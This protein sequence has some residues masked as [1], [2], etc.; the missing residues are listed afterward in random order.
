MF[1]FHDNTQEEWITSARF[2]LGE[3][4]SLHARKICSFLE[5]CQSSHFRS[6]S[7]LLLACKNVLRCS[8]SFITLDT[9]CASNIAL[10]ND[11]NFPFESSEEKIS[12][13]ALLFTLCL[14]RNSQLIT[15]SMNAFPYTLFSATQLHPFSS[16]TNRNGS[17]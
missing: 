2:D 16:R 1:V 9:V 10:H 12:V 8:I 11:L 15:R 5:T 3:L 17:N 6:T 13:F 7:L 4:L 14:K